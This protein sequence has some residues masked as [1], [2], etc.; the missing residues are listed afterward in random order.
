[1]ENLINYNVND[2]YGATFEDLLT[3]NEVNDII[4]IFEKYKTVRGATLSDEASKSRRSDIAWIGN[5]DETLWIYNKIT[6]AARSIN[7]ELYNFDLV[8]AE[9]IQYT[10]YQSSENGE[11]DWHKDTAMIGDNI[12]KLSII[13]LLSDKQEFSG[14]SFLISPEGGKPTEILMKKGRMIVFP[15]WI[16]HCVTPVLEG[17]RR[18]L[19]MWLY[20][21]KFK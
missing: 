20:G 11:Y 7:N 4:K 19:V 17:T 2:I 14:G 12:R 5:S 9:P 6:N 3:E 15:S 16:P 10:K 18:S 8:G 13:I 1:M 21:K